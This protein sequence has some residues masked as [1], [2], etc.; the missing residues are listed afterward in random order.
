MDELRI[1]KK[2][3]PVSFTIRI[4][5]TIADFYDNLANRTNR[6]RNEIISLALEYA[7]ERISVDEVKK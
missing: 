4:D 2:T 1:T 7:K 5:R 3:E 6:S